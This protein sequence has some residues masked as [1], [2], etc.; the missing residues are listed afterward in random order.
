MVRLSLAVL[1]SAIALAPVQCAGKPDPDLRRQDTAGDGLWDLAQDFKAKGNDDSYKATLRF[2]VARYPG[3]RRAVK[4]RDELHE[5]V[6]PA[7]SK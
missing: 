7:S 6:P 4:A 2:L 5:D 1:V 3:H